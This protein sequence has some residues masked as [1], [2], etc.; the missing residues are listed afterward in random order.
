[1][2]DD[3]TCVQIASAADV[4][5]MNQRRICWHKIYPT[6]PA[7]CLHLRWI[8]NEWRIACNR[9]SIDRGQQPPSCTCILI[10]Q[11]PTYVVQP[12]FRWC[13]PTIIHC[14][15]KTSNFLFF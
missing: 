2:I 12:I 10:H 6:V 14:V 11:P 5:P 9:P 1:V 3:L 8:I 7:T 15:P 4:H 13:R